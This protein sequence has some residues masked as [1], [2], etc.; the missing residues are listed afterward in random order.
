VK[1]SMSI[2]DSET[3]D[4]GIWQEILSSSMPWGRLAYILKRF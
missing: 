3:M 1:I 2:V 4:V